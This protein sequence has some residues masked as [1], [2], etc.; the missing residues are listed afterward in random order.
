MAQEDE[1]LDEQAFYETYGNLPSMPQI[2]GS[3]GLNEIYDS[4]A[5]EFDLKPRAETL[6]PV[7]TT[8]QEIPEELGFMDAMGEAFTN[9][10]R[11]IPVVSSISEVSE[12]AD[13]YEASKA[14]EAETATQ[15]QY[16]MVAKYLAHQQAEKSF[17]YQVGS[18]LAQLPAFVGEFAMGGAIAK[19][20]GMAFGGKALREAIE[21]AGKKAS[22]RNIGK[23]LQRKAR[24]AATAEKAAQYTNKGN[25][26]LEAGSRGVGEWAGGLAGAAAG[27]MGVIE[28]ATGPVGLAKAGYWGGRSGAS[29]FRRA[30]Q[31]GEM[32]LSP[33]E[34]DRMQVY[35]GSTV[36][37]FTDSLPAGMADM[38]IEYLSESMGPEI[39]RLP[40]LRMMEAGQMTVAQ[41]FI[42]KGK[43]KSLL[44]K[45]RKG[46]WNGPIE[47]FMEERFGGTVR[48]MTLVGEEEFIVQYDDGGEMTYN[49][50]TIFPEWKQMAAELTAFTVPGGMAAGLTR[51]MHG[52][53]T[54]L[55][56]LSQDLSRTREEQDELDR[57]LRATAVNEVGE[58]VV[59]DYLNGNETQREEALQ[60]LLNN[61]AVVAAGKQAGHPL[62]LE[63]SGN[64]TAQERQVANEILL[65]I[66]PDAK[67]GDLKL[68][69]VEEMSEFQQEILDLASDT[70]N[71][72]LISG[73]EKF[74]KN[75]TAVYDKRTDTVFVNAHMSRSRSV[76]HLLS[77]VY[78]H[79]PVHSID[80]SDQEEIKEI[81]R[82][83]S[84]R[85]TDLDPNG[86]LVGKAWDTYFGKWNLHG[87]KAAAKKANKSWESLTEA[88]RNELLE[89]QK[90]ETE[91]LLREQA[92]AEGISYEKLKELESRAVLSEMHT[93]LLV[94]LNRLGGQKIL[95]DIA[96][97]E[98]GVAG[99]I[100]DYLVKRLNKVVGAGR[101]N[102]N[103]QARYLRVLK[104]LQSFGK[105]TN[106]SG[107]AIDKMLVSEL[108][109]KP[110]LSDLEGLDLADLQMKAR[111]EGLKDEDIESYNKTKLKEEIAKARGVTHGRNTLK[112]AEAFANALRA[113]AEAR[114]AKA[115]NEQ[116]PTSDAEAEVEA[117]VEG[118]EEADVETQDRDG[119]GRRI[120]RK[121]QE[122]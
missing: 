90:P 45:L 22:Q 69:D 75:A 92:K 53:P 28:A 113:L 49:L 110:D 20:A 86:D 57:I 63:D 13:L 99:R 81:S 104:D 2:G 73:S 108:A 62:F 36:G 14:V 79:E 89:K 3:R 78:G 100:R 95:D 120:F 85:I 40:M 5:A 70:V 58:D 26:L 48:S 84:E 10:E 66:D 33:D 111:G 102:T 88:E 35:F 1:V 56:E 68:H 54:E 24:T 50:S 9:W 55:G 7:Q 61:E 43:Y 59:D 12:L 4:L 91:K 109:K 11:F 116:D 64:A 114:Q 34:Y 105:D 42:Q 97:N 31:K 23:A 76:L 83:L 16:E 80:V 107:S 41:R 27:R 96:K 15:E 121:F 82:K 122:A 52:A 51:V 106:V 6:A 118:Q 44:D 94:F 119:I 17:G 93:P 47:E 71:V 101:L 60:T 8:E 74:N 65:S 32:Y 30:M 37:D 19:K 115:D 29:A 21:T 98:P 117:Q 46:G 25:E 72:R 67:E 77:D 38:F 39:M 112:V 18:I 103:Q 87:A